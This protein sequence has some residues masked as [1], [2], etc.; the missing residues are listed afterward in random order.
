[1]KQFNR[2][3]DQYSVAFKLAQGQSGLNNDRLLV[4]A[5]QRGVSYQLAVMMTGVPLSDEQRENGWRW[6]QW[7]DQAG[8]FYR[9]VVQ[10][11]N[12]RGGKEDL[13][14]IPLA[15]LK[16]A[17]PPEDPDAMDI[18]LLKATSQCEDDA[19][20]CS[21]RH[22]ERPWTKQQNAPRRKKGKHALPR[23]LRKKKTPASDE[24]TPLTSYMKDNGITEERA[25]ELLGLFYEKEAYDETSESTGDTSL[26][27][28]S[29]A[30]PEISKRG[31][32]IPTTAHPTDGGNVTETIA[33]I[34]SGAMICCVD[35]DFA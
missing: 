33:L 21:V 32:F 6:E 24:E 34:D 35:L 2:D 22:E 16:P 4:D 14:F 28:P 12:L 19:L 17:S 20:L 23:N 15:P 13:G 1:M 11:Y 3:F 7:L 26:E 9:N 5:L 31:I 10:L 27:T 18:D 29:R 25:L 8:R 30:T